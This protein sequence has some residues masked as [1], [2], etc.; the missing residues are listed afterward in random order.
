M[1]LCYRLSFCTNGLVIHPNVKDMRKM[2]E[3]LAKIN[4][5]LNKMGMR[6]IRELKWCDL[7]CGEGHSRRQYPLRT[8]TN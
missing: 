2:H 5:F 8:G 3:R 6:E 1:P 4:P 7:Y